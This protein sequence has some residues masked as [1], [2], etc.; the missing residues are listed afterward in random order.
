MNPSRRSPSIPQHVGMTRMKA[1]QK[2]SN[3]H[4]EFIVPCA[5]GK[6]LRLSARTQVMGIL[7]VTPNSFSDGGKYFCVEAAVVHALEMAKAAVDLLDLGAESTTPGADTVTAAEEIDRLLPVIARLQVECPD[8]PISADTYKAEVAEAVLTAG[9]AIINDVWGFRY[10]PKMA[11][12]VGRWGAAAIIMH[13]SGNRQTKDIHA[14]T[15]SPCILSD[16]FDF[17]DK[18][19]EDAMVHGICDA[20]II[21]DPDVEFGK[22]QAQNLAMLSSANALCSR[23]NKPVLVG[24]SR[25]SFIDRVVPSNV[26]GRLPGSLAA[27]VLAVANGNQII[28]AHDVAEAVQAVRGADEILRQAA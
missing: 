7:N 23:Y 2:S 6:E 16:A 27:H 22:S 20:S 12:V 11:E 17:F 5:N 28:R 9:A 14:R 24:A 8:S 10:D 26:T 21:L 4:P 1:T 15:Q 3:L 19:L 25:K 18:A 13:S